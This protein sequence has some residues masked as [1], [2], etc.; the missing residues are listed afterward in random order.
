[1]TVIADAPG[2]IRTQQ[3]DSELGRWTQVHW[4][5][6]AS[7]PLFGAVERIWDFEGV[8]ACARERVFPSGR[9][10]VVVQLDDPHRP[11]GADVP[12]PALCVDGL[13]TVGTTIEAPAK[14]CRV[15]GISLHPLGAFGVLASPLHELSDRSVDL[16]AV[17]GRTTGS[18]GTNLDAARTGRERICV[19]IDWTRRRFAESRPVDTLVATALERI[20]RGYGALAISA[21]EELGGRS[22][23]RF[24]AAFRDHVGLAPKRYARIVRFRRAMELLA[25]ASMP[26]V[27][28]AEVSGYYDQAH[29]TAEFRVHSGMTPRAY[30]VAERYP[31]SG[32]LADYTAEND[33]AADSYFQDGSASQR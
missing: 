22:R 9:F 1:V 21:I 10:G 23:S 2:D 15:L 6:A 8:L 14:R 17:I 7:D 20:E 32:H 3:I 11:A 13:A 25:S 28:V 5:P 33:F 27:A 31:G 29:L 18:L 30:Q 4:E 24:A 19:A 26:L 16:H 12:F